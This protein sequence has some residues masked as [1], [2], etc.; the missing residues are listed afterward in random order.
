MNKEL[1]EKIELLQREV[2]ESK[3]E[4]IDSKQKIANLETSGK[5]KLFS[6]LNVVAGMALSLIISSAVLFAVTKPYTF[7][8]GDVISAK[9]MNENFDTIYSAFNNFSAIQPPVGSIVAWHKNMGAGI[10]SL[11]DGWVECNGQ[12]LSDSASVLNGQTIPNLNGASAGV[13]SPNLSGKYTMFLRGGTT[14]GVGQDHMFQDHIHVVGTSYYNN[15]GGS[16]VGVVKS[17]SLISEY[18]TGSATN[19]NF[20][21]ETRPVNMSVVWIMR[22]K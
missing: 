11:P 1:I 4:I 5:I 19:G 18:S 13:N 3:K 10:P 7:I 22:V 16:S 15:T 20:G 14:S 21:T 6:K 2:E 12:V 9:S 8:D 17:N